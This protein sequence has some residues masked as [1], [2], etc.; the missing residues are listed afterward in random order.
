MS[1]IHMKAA[2]I[3]KLAVRLQWIE[4]SAVAMALF[5]N[6]THLDVPLLGYISDLC[7]S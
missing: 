4:M 3:E 2:G 7:S 6:S 1:T 5:P